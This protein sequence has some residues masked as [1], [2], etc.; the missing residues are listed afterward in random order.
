MAPGERSEQ[1]IVRFLRGEPIGAL[2]PKDVHKIYPCMVCLDNAVSVPYMA[3]YFKEQF[4]PVFPRKEFRHTVTTF[5]T[6]N[7]TDVEN[8]LGYLRRFRLSDILESY[9]ANNR[10]M[11]TS[12]SSSGYRFSRVLIPTR[13]FFDKDFWS[14]LAN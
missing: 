1:G 3:A 8:L 13:P 7:V 11:L 12:L 14:L 2:V 6:L 5:F 4:K 9:H 10:R